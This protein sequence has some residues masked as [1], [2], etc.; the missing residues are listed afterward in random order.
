MD[1]K[2]ENIPLLDFI[3]TLKIYCGLPLRKLLKNCMMKENT[4]IPMQAFS[5]NLKI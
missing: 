1:Y 5:R 2:Y 4:T 3:K